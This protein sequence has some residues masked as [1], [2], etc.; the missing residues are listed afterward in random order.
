MMKKKGVFDAMCPAD[1]LVVPSLGGPSSRITRVVARL[2]R[3]RMTAV[4]RGLYASFEGFVETP[5]GD[6]QVTLLTVSSSTK[7]TATTVS[8]PL[9]SY[10]RLRTQEILYQSTPAA[11]HQQMSAHLAT[12]LERCRVE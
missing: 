11:R 4:W 10:D 6:T 7:V 9:L 8:F 2:S 1:L 5:C 12:R 3:E